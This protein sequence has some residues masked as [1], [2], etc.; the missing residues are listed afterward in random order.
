VIVPLAKIV[1]LGGRP[2]PADVER[3]V[4]QSG[5]SRYVLVDAA[6]E[7]SGYLHIKDVLEL[8]EDEV[9]SPVPQKFVRQLVSIFAGTELEDAL[10]T[11]RRGGNHLARVFDEQGRTLG[12][13]V[14]EDVIEELVGEVQDATRR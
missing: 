14:L 1:S 2:T 6:G 3:A 11:L 4:A 5:F 8:D 9:D 7:P 13:L 12:V 10:A